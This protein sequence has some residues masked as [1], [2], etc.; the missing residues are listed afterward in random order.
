MGGNVAKK[1]KD[2]LED[3]LKESVIT[4]NN[5]LSYKYIKSKE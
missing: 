4:K 3:K 1:A 2:D 5:S